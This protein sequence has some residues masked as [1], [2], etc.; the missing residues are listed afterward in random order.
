MSSI[1]PT[2]TRDPRELQASLPRAI[3]PDAPTPLWRAIDEA[4]NV[5]KEA[6]DERAVILVLSDGKDSGPIGFRQEGRQ[7]G[8][9][10]RSR[11]R[12]GRDDLRRRHAQ[13]RPA[14]EHAGSLVR[15]DCRRR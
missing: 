9:G 15:V 4:L 12:A 6:G 10:H 8:R 2:F 13:P 7:P 14:T 5:F 1:S 3:A 11:A